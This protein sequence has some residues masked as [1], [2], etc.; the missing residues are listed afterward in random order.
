MDPQEILQQIG[1]REFRIKERTELCRNWLQNT[2]KFGEKCSFAHGIEQVQKKHHCNGRYKL[3]RCNGYHNNLV[4]LYGTRCQFAHLL[5]EN[6][7]DY[8]QALAENSRQINIRISNVAEPRIL[9]FNV[10][11]EGL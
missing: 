5:R 10:V 8:R 4:C 9:E 7:S 2:C 11:A 1:E 3:T 6:Y